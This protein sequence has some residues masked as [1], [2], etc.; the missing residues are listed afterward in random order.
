[1]PKIYIANRSSVMND[2]DLKTIT[3]ALQ[4]QVKGHFAPIWRREA[5]LTF[6][7]QHDKLPTDGWWLVVLDTSDQADALGY[8]DITV[9]GL[10]LGKAFAKSDLDN[11]YKP[12]VTISHEL[13]E[14]MADPEINLSAQV[15]DR[16]YAYEVCD[17]C[18][19]DQPDYSID[20]TYVSDF[21]TPSWFYPASDVR[22]PF[23]F[24]EKIN[25][26]LA[27]LP[28]G[29]CQYLE[30]TGSAGWQQVTAD[31]ATERQRPRVGS[32]RERRRTKREHWQRSEPRSLNPFK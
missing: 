18:E 28:G 24:R 22:G 9:E 2:S 14:M 3:A 1:M 16:I 6:V 27:L 11:G 31:K 4:K 12:S 30:L 29:Y 15:K 23:D 21:V 19:A 17:P 20:G 26:P 13:L 5:D 7:G 25:S 8:H 32:R 10:P